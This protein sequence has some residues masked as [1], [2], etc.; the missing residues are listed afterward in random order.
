LSP[1]V[2][3]HETKGSPF[4]VGWK[5]HVGLKILSRVVFPPE[6]TKV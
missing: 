5:H 4:R 6:T 1:V 2:C 3:P